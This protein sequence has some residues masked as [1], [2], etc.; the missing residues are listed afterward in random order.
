MKEGK[1]IPSEVSLPLLIVRKN[2]STV[3][4]NEWEFK[5]PNSME[6]YLI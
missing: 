1:N 4:G 6:I 3:C 5:S 2:C